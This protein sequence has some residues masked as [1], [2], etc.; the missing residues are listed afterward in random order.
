M[1]WNGEMS[2]LTL[3]HLKQSGADILYVVS[4]NSE[5]QAA[6]RGI[7][8]PVAFHGKLANHLSSVDILIASTSAPH[9]IVH[10]DDI[11]KAMTERKNK[12][13]FLIDIAVPRDIDP[14]VHDLEEC[15]SL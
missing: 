7:S 13:L 12:P 5:R 1:G 10:F 3:S 14:K 11:K 15:L 9:P 8:G 4:R 6:C 2:A